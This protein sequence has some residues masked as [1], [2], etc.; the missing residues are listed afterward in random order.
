[1]QFFGIRRWIM[2]QAKSD[3]LEPVEGEEI[4]L[5]LGM[6][7][8]IMVFMLV[9]LVLGGLLIW[10]WWTE[11]NIL[12]KRINSAGAFVGGLGFI[13]G[14]V[15]LPLLTIALFSNTRFV[16]GAD[17]LQQ[18]SAKG[19]VTL[20]I[21]Y[22]NIAQIELVSEPDKKPFI[23]IDLEDVEDPETRCRDYASTKKS[24]GWHYKIV[25]V[26]WKLPIEEVY[27]HILARYQEFQRTS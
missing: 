14:I 9:L 25:G 27:E 18:V 8:K 24:A 16:I 2:S 21:P 19:L 15:F 1:M 17:R 3:S 20:Q 26:A 11:F 7:L 12:G 4:H 5:S 23:G 10:A 6:I 13:M 22:R